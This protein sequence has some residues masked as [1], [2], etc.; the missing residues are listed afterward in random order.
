MKRFTVYSTLPDGGN[1]GYGE[2]GWVNHAA[3][4]YGF[5]QSG[6]QLQFERKTP[7][8]ASYIVVDVTAGSY[9]AV[10]RL[11]FKY[12]DMVYCD[13]TEI[14]RCGISRTMT[15]AGSISAQGVA[16]NIVLTEYDSTDTAIG[17]TRIAD[18]TF[19]D[20]LALPYQPA[21]PF[22]PSYPDRLR[23]PSAAQYV[24]LEQVTVRACSAYNS[25]AAAVTVKMA[26]GTSD[27]TQSLPNVSAPAQIGLKATSAF[28]EVA[29]RSIR[30]ERE[31]CT[32]DKIFVTWWSSQDGGYK[33]YLCDIVSKGGAIDSRTRYNAGFEF[34]DTVEASPSLTVRFPNLTANDWQY[35]RDILYSGEV[36]VWEPETTVPGSYAELIGRRAVVS[37]DIGE[38]KPNDI[39]D[40]EI[41]LTFETVTVL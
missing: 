25:A 8:T 40:F 36:R 26:S 39:K 35:C 10:M 18:I 24:S 34:G 19:C 13:I 5:L 2:P 7:G 22:A 16:G 21:S 12:S 33:S 30:I 27:Y 41:G 14:V 17:D 29:G 20:A 4:I 6:L 32:S 28:V 9:N 38:W 31:S 3:G 23:M 1:V 11:S 37:G 15:T